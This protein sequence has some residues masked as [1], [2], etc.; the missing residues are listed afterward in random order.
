[1]TPA[2]SRAR[3]GSRICDIFHTS[4]TLPRFAFRR[5][6]WEPSRSREEDCTA[7]T[8]PALLG[9]LRAGAGKAGC[10]CCIFSL[11]ARSSL[12]V[13]V[14]EAG[15]RQRV[16]SSWGR[17]GRQGSADD[18]AARLLRVGSALGPAAA[19]GALCRCGWSIPQRRRRK[20]EN[21]RFID[22]GI[23]FFNAGALGHVADVSFLDMS[24]GG[25]AGDLVFRLGGGRASR[26][27]WAPCNYCGVGCKFCTGAALCDAV[28]RRAS[29][30]TRSAGK[31]CFGGGKGEK[32][33]GVQAAKT[34]ARGRRT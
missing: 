14:V 24:A 18:A 1:M 34:T 3:W 29:T 27:P 12:G 33:S 10:K 13:H 30:R 23:C 21:G 11:F 5:S 2:C 19:C 20:A 17:C 26:G 22:F 25:R 16:P 7:G 9:A 15:Q 6:L 4:S 28:G 32:G 31:G 8:V